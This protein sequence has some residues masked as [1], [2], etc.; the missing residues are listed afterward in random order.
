MSIII[1]LTEDEMHIVLTALDR[2]EESAF[3]ADD[4]VELRKK[5]VALGWKHGLFDRPDDE[6]D[7]R[8][9]HPLD[10]GDR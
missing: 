9:P 2:M 8:V 3:M 10:F 5:M 6:Y 4:V 1:G 7:P